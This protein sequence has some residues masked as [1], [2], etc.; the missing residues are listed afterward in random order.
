MLPIA[1]EQESLIRDTNRG[2]HVVGHPDGLS[3][4]LELDSDVG[5]DPGLLRAES[6]DDYGFKESIHGFPLFRRM[7]AG[8]DFERR[9]RRGRLGRAFSVAA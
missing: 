8:P 6:K 5:G 9:D 1:S 3:V 7:C 4:A 2:D